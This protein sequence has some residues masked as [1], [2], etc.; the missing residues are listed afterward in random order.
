MSHCFEQ[1]SLLHLYETIPSTYNFQNISSD[2]VPHTL[3]SQTVTAAANLEDI[4]KQWSHS[5]AYNHSK[6]PT[7]TPG[8]WRGVKRPL[9]PTRKEDSGKLKCKLPLQV[10]FRIEIQYNRHLRF[11]W[12][13][14]FFIP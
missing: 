10:Q 9:N 8:R 13:P 5:S 12:E 4:F 7:S 6:S 2:P 3:P 1:A 14:N 11:V